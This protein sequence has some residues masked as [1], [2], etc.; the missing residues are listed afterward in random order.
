MGQMFSK[1]V[2]TTFS[3]TQDD[4]RT[5]VAGTPLEVHPEP[6]NPFDSN[7]VG[8]RHNGKHL[9]HLP[10]ATAKMVTELLVES[11]VS[12]S[13]SEVTGGGVGENVGCNIKLTW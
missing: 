13:V 12:C 11:P 1:I 3:G 10:R 9:G 4:L 7:A 5:L 6:D 8:I 2:G